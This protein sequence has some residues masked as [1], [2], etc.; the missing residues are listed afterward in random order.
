MK[1][2]RGQLSARC[3]IHPPHAESLETPYNRG[4]FWSLK[5]DTQID[6]GAVVDIREGRVDATLILSSKD[7]PEPEIIWTHSE[8]FVISG[9]NMESA[10]KKAILNSFS[11]LSTSGQ[12]TSN[13][14]GVFSPI[15]LIQVS[16]HAPYA[17]TIS[18]NV[19]VKGEKPFKVTKKLVRELEERAE[20]DARTQQMGELVTKDLKLRPLS[21][22][23]VAISIN[24]YPTKYPYKSHALELSLCQHIS[25]TTLDILP[26]LEEARDKHLPKTKIDADSFASLFF[27][28]MLS[29]APKS[30]DCS[31]LYIGENNSELLIVRDG[32]PQSASF[33]QFGLDD[34]ATRVSEKTNISLGDVRNITKTNSVDPLSLANDGKKALVASAFNSYEAE[35]KNLLGRTGDSLSLPKTVYLLAPRSHEEHFSTLVERLAKEVSGTTHSVHPIT[36]EFF[37]FGQNVDPMLV[38]LAYVFHKKLYEDN[39]FD[40]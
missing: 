20:A 15:S 9:S 17:Y 32:L 29:L 12:R 18:R 22:S 33:S 34:M 27:R 8:P 3:F 38:A 13:Q 25:L 6:V 21:S 10:L 24:G 30:L 31:L 7:K 28:M 35:L 2:T 11:D 40:D 36:T 37:G 39:F 5:S 4:M 14:K 16:I 1:T 26:Y 23:A 19:S